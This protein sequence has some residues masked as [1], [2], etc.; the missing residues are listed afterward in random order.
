MPMTMNLIA[1][2]LSALLLAG[3]P[4]SA[5]SG[6]GSFEHTERC[7]DDFCLRVDAS[8]MYN[9]NGGLV[10]DCVATAPGALITEVTCGVAE[11]A[12]SY[13]HDEATG[14]VAGTAGVYDYPEPGGHDVE[15]CFEASAEFLGGLVVQQE[16]TCATILVGP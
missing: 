4:A 12:A 13:Q 6:S 1:L 7:D 5:G 3:A 14:P 15:V 16:H 2:V 11:Y 8:S 10:W 9:G